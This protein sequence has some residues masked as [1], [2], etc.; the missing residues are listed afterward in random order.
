[1]PRK[2]QL[3]FQTDE[4]RK[5]TKTRNFVLGFVLIFLT[6]GSISAVILFKDA[7]FSA[8]NPTTTDE[9]LTETETT[10]QAP[11]SGTG[12]FLTFCIDDDEAIRFISVIKACADTKKF[13]VCS[14]SPNERATLDG[15]K[16]TLNEHYTKGGV[17]KL[18]RAVETI[19]GFKVNKY[20]CA[21]GDGFKKSINAFGSFQYNVPEKVAYKSESAT[22]SLAEG[23]QRMTG[24]ILYRYMLYCADNGDAGLAEESSVICCILDSFV[25][26]PNFEKSDK[27]YDTIINAVTSDITIVDFTGNKNILEAFCNDTARPRSNQVA[28]LAEL[29]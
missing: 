10:T 12:Y 21:D 7:S 3:H 8:A 20:I 5:A 17:M 28:L 4:K 22:I 15:D 24:D 9:N 18:V 25:S 23:V 19:G 27:L 26:T 1:M 14:F 11:V 16:L 13:S 29:G 2:S 6:F